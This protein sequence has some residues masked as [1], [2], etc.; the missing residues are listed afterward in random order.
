MQDFDITQYFGHIPVLDKGHV[1]LIDGMVSDPR[2]K[3]VNAARVSFHKESTEL[4]EKD[5]KLITF[6]KDHE[7]FSVFRHSYFTFRVKAPLCVFRQWWKYQVASDWVESENVGTIEIPETNWNEVSG[8]YIEFIPE[9]Y[10]PSEIRGQS[11]DNKQGSAGVIHS[12]CGKNSVEFFEDSCKLIYN[13]YEAMI[14]AGVAK[15]QA[16]MILPQNVY[17]ECVWTISLQGLLFFLHQRLKAD[18]QYEIR[19]YAQAVAKLIAPIL[20]PIDIYE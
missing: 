3:V 6:L 9:F 17:S 13:Q 15:E 1:E 14:R 20:E 5:I 8:R 2:L 4:T 18:A 11:K 16:R 10:I 12:V 7:H 19:A